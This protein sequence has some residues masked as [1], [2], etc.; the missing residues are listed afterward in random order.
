MTD[1]KTIF[2]K[3]IKFL[4]TDL[5]T[6]ARELYGSG[7]QTAALAFTQDYAPGA[8]AVTEEYNG[9]A[10]TAGGSMNTAR[11]SGV[12]G[13]TQTATL[14]TGGHPALT[15][16]EIYDGSSWVTAPNLA[17]GKAYAGGAGTTTAGIAMGGQ[18]SLTATE[19]FTAETTALNLKT[20]T[21]S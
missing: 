18:N 7:T 16:S 8:S 11:K 3:K 17:T 10:W 13:G 9:S 21:D 15:I 14:A 4:T 12:G 1:Y 19:E 6:A 2:G 20:I 5:S